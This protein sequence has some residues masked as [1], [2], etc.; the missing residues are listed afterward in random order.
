MRKILSAIIF[1]SLLAL[2]GG[3][4]VFS[5][6]SFSRYYRSVYAEKCLLD[7]NIDAQKSI[8]V[9][10]YL[11]T[12][13]YN[14][15]V[16][17]AATVQ[18]STSPEETIDQVIFAFT[19]DFFLK[20]PDFIISFIEKTKENELPYSCTILLTA[21]DEKTVLETTEGIPCASDY[22]AERLYETNSL[23][24]FVITD[25]DYFP[26]QIITTGFETI[27][28]MWI[29]RSVQKSFHT[30]Q[31]DI[32][33]QQS[34]LYSSKSNLFKTNSRLSAFT[35]NEITSTCFPLG[36]STKDLEILA[37]LEKEIIDTRKQGGNT[38]YNVISARTF[39]IWINES[40]LTLIYLAFAGIALFTVCFSSFAYNA[41][42]EAV[43]KDLSRTWF[44]TPVYII[45]SAV[46]LSIFQLIFSA[47]I[48]TPILF[49]SL[50]TG[51][52]LCSLFVVS[53]IQNYYKF[54]I[55]LA[56][57]SFQ[58]L[59]LCALNI[60][61][62]AFVD[63]SL[64]FVF[65]IE[66][67]IVLCAGKSN[68]K[69]IALIVMILMVVPFIQ[70]ATSLYLNINHERL[71]ELFSSN[72]SRSILFSM[73]MIPISFQ[74]TKCILILNLKDKLSS[75]KKSTSMITG[76]VVSAIFSAILFI[77]F[78]SGT[79][80]LTKKLSS[81]KR[82]ELISIQENKKEELLLF[83]STSDNFDL[84]SHKID[85]SSQ[86]NRRIL[87]TLVTLSADSNPL[88]ECNFNYTMKSP[89]EASIEIPDGAEDKISLIFSSDYGVPIHIKLETYILS[90]ENHAIHETREIKLS[91]KKD[92]GKA[93]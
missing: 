61:V 36:R 81:E 79:A 1:T 19:Q 22:Y 85:I 57:I 30:N 39:S 48:N 23:C 38:L 43:F 70:P 13:P 51:F 42:N 12:F 20:D 47:T 41:R 8:I 50:K 53:A 29:V 44:L 80:I 56:S 25:E 65:I 73:I 45:L 14:I 6:E 55:S 90:D 92:D 2:S 24:C 86:E 62:F 76:I 27:S 78:L 35:K 16:E 34:I 75:G 87:R 88:Y 7:R 15:T 83:H 32:D 4:K 59:I 91:G 67:L 46:F 74:W 64:M 72:F 93:I 31:K 37:F 18:E 9:P 89:T 3:L 66:Y 84:I 69:P 10:D 68:R 5:E 26:P 52:A 11:G 17:I 60:F 71:A 77:L 28:P 21:D 40:L 82:Q 49:F 54:R 63:L 58:T 33:V